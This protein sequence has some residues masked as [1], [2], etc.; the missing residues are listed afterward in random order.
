MGHERHLSSTILGEGESLGEGRWCLSWPWERVRSVF[1]IKGRWAAGKGGMAF[2]EG[3]VLLM[4]WR[5]G[6]WWERL[7]AASKAQGDSFVKRLKGQTGEFGHWS[8]V[9]WDYLGVLFISWHGHVY[10]FKRSLWQTCGGSVRWGDALSR[11]TC[12][13]SL[14]YMWGRRRTREGAAAEITEETGWVKG[15][16]WD[17][18]KMSTV[19]EE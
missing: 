10:I 12:S 16:L 8:M 9:S 15:E 19:S 11:N 18:V 17:L 2:E 4:V 5:A 7:E 3:Q 13:E 14:H 1:L 6:E